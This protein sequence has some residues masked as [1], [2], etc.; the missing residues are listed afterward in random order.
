MLGIPIH[1]I[2]VGHFAN[3]SDVLLVILEKIRNNPYRIR[4]F[5]IPLRIK[6]C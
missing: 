2:L 4:G 5:S 6:F 1:Y 3:D